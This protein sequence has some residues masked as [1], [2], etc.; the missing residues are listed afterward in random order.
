[1]FKNNEK[2]RKYEQKFIQIIQNVN[3]VKR[4][5]KNVNKNMHNV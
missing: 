2:Y 5:M 4:Y 1:M 3:Y